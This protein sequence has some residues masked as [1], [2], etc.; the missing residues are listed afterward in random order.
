M[1][2]SIDTND[3]P[4]LEKL[5]KENPKAAQEIIGAFTALMEEAVDKEWHELPQLFSRGK[6]KLTFADIVKGVLR[7][8]LDLPEMNP[9]MYD[10]LKEEVHP[11]SMFG[12]RVNLLENKVTYRDWRRHYDLPSSTPVNAD[13]IASIIRKSLRY[14]RY[15]D[16]ESMKEALVN[17]QVTNWRGLDNP[18]MIANLPFVP[19]LRYQK[20]H[21]GDLHV[22][23]FYDEI[24]SYDCG[25]I[26]IER[27][28]NFCPA[29]RHSSLDETAFDEYAICLVCNAGFRIEAE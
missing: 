16:V 14:Y 10:V 26:P 20:E 28:E 6:E 15:V 9:D 23:K 19:A 24:G 7:G 21:F 4:N 27:D 3:K 5:M 2:F 25:P 8:S 13:T 1:K 18:H 29:C 17:N 22:G 12:G 11:F